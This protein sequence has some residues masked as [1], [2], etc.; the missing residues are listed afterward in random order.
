MGAW[1]GR[2]EGLENVLGGNTE[3]EKSSPGKDKGR[4]CRAESN[5]APRAVWLVL[6]P[7]AVTSKCQECPAG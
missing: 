6:G 5:L 2:R 4:A 3:M 7:L 1:H